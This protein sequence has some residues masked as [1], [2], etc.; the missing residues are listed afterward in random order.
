MDTALCSSWNGDNK[1]SWAPHPK[2][3]TQQVQAQ[4]GSQNQLQ[5]AAPKYSLKTSCSDKGILTAEFTANGT[6]RKQNNKCK[7]ERTN[8]SGMQ[9]R[10]TSAVHWARWISPSV[11][12]FVCL[13][14]TGDCAGLR[15]M[16]QF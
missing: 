1:D 3:T 10:I 14:N 7:S 4:S 2:D 13:H 16:E 5:R 6:H 9:S 8:P 11:K 12:L 15:K